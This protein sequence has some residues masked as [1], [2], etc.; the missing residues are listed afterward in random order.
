MKRELID[1]NICQ[2]M[3]RTIGFRLEMVVENKKLYQMRPKQSYNKTQHTTLKSLEELLRRERMKIPTAIGSSESKDKLILSFILATSLLHLYSGEWLKG[4]WN[5]QNIYFMVN[6]RRE[7]SLSLT[8]PYFRTRCTPGKYL[9]PKEVASLCN[10][11]CYPSILALGIMLLEIALGTKLVDK[12]GEDECQE[13][14]DDRYNADVLIALRVFEDW[15]KESE[16]LVS[17]KIPLGLKS[18]IQAC[19]SPVRLP[20]TDPPPSEKHIRQYIFT[21]VVVPLG[22]ALSETYLIS[23]E[24]LHQEIHRERKVEDPELFDS[25]ET[26]K[27][28][29]Q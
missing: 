19:L 26:L 17:R 20:Y 5:N 18:A 24:T 14:P 4:N 27:I 10:F 8:K 15:T 21:D 7:G 22:T 3:K 9:S 11:H 25:F 12:G 6:S 16:R 13:E 2:I 23:P 28:N 1:F 29:E